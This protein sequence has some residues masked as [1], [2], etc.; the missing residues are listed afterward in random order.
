MH[1]SD[2]I[3][4]SDL[5]H[6]RGWRSVMPSYHLSSCSLKPLRS[7]SHWAVTVNL[8]RGNNLRIHPLVGCDGLEKDTRNRNTGA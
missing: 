5:A 7:A 4:G 6:W 8:T 2:S 1:C 3:G